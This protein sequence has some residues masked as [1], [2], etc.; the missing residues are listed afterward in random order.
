MRDDHTML[1]LVLLALLI[2]ALGSYVTARWELRRQQ[3]ETRELEGKKQVLLAQRQE[4]EERLAALD[5]P[6]LLRRLAWERLRM[7]APGERVFTFGDPP[8]A[9]DSP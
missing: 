9:S 6:E 2:Y 4:L 1:R 7:V 8:A 3:A 5:D